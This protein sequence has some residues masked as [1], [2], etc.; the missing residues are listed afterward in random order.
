[1]PKISSWYMKDGALIEGD[2]KLYRC[3][4]GTYDIETTN[5]SI[6]FTLGRDKAT[7]QYTVIVRVDYSQK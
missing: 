6:G 2:T 4:D 5:E 7:N 1:M 3:D